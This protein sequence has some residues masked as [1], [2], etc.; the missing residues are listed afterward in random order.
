MFEIAPCSV[1]PLAFDSWARDLLRWSAAKRKQ[2]KKKVEKSQNNYLEYL[3]ARS[4]MQ[5]T[6]TETVHKWFF[7]ETKRK[8][9][10][11]GSDF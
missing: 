10:R 8:P 6:T 5:P 11:L 4:K 2:N 7:L 9:N 1:A 3:F